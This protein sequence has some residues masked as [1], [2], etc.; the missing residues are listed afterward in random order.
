MK[1]HMKGNLLETGSGFVMGILFIAILL[2]AG[3]IAN[4]A[5]TPTLP[6]GN[7]GAT[8][9]ISYIAAGATAGNG[10][11]GMANFSAQFPTIGTEAL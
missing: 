9:N 7:Q 5:L 2:G 3:A 8:Q 11:V 6:V 10:T 4:V 1:G